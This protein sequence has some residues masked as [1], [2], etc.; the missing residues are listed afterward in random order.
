MVPNIGHAEVGH[1]PDVISEDWTDHR[2][3]EKIKNRYRAFKAT[4]EIYKALR[5]KSGSGPFW[6]DLKSDFRQIISADGYDDR[7]GKIN[8]LLAEKGL[9]AVPR[10]SKNDWIDAALDRKEDRI[11]MREGFEE[12]DW[13]HFHKAAKI[14]LAIVLEL[15]KA[16]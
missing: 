6:T 16:L 7:K 13:Y 1:S 4:A 10:Y 8:D 2:I 15:T 14:Q 11:V 5:R 3:G 12:T 9:G